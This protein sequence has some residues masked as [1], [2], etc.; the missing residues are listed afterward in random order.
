M[1][2]SEQLPQQFNVAT[3]FVDRNVSEGRGGQAAFFC[4]DRVLTYGDVL[5]LTNRTGNVLKALGVA[6]EER[7]LV[8]CLDTPEFLGTFWGA[9]KIGAVPI[10]VNTLLRAPDYLYVLDDSRA[11]VA[12]ISAPL[13]AEAGPVL[14]RARHLQHVLVAGGVPAAYLG[15][16]EQVARASSRLEAAATSRDDPAFW[17]YSSGS[18]GFP[19][20]T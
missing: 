20:G 15:Y 19:K 6:M 1:N 5:D 4:E 12:V 18:T 13:V 2:A 14:E 8:L 16:E 17:L 9:I 10:P 7:V 11:K 3:H